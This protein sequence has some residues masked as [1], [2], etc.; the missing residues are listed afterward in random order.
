MGTKIYTKRERE[1]KERESHANA[2]HALVKA[3][4]PG[5]LLPVEQARALL[6]QSKNVD[7]VKDVA[8]KA[9]AVALYLRMKDAS[10]DSQNDAAEIRLR[11]ERRLGEL[12]K[13]MPKAKAGRPSEI[14]PKDGPISYADQGID[15]R[16]A[17]KWQALAS[18]P[19][20]KFE[21]FVDD[22][23]KKGERITS[24][25]LTQAAKVTK[26]AAKRTEKEKAAKSAPERAQVTYGDAREFL[27]S[28][29][30]ESVDLLLTDPP[31]STDVDDFET[32]ASWIRL[33]LS[34]VKKTG[35]AYVCVGAYS[36]ELLTYLEI[37]RESA[38]IDRSQVLVWTYRNTLG[39]SPSHD[40]KLNW[41]AI[42]YLRGIDA[43][44]LDCPELVEQFSV[45][46][47]NAP[48]GRLG[49]RYHAWQKPDALGERLVRHS[50]RAGDLVVDPFACTGTFLLAAARLGRKAIGCDISA[51]NLAI[52]EQRGCLV[53]MNQEAA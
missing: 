42:L 14:G 10:I 49:D 3:T 4:P 8:D 24:N 23:R 41:Q 15:K 2:R 18:I 6:A 33:A 46:D 19:E 45:Q 34:K 50:T 27:S 36:R 7:E 52:A 32:F 38:W 12:M 35:R 9:K 40:Y 48:D 5:Q 31:Y 47:I 22:A 44:A 26:Q 53:T 28:L 43:P 11:A 29:D 13:E 17:A 20:K 30:D 37:L 25:A 1:Q 16:D 51:A 21:Q 39:P